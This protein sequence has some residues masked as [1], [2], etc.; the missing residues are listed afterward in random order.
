MARV[1]RVASMPRMSL[2][3]IATALRARVGDDCG[4]NAT[5]RFD[6]GAD[7]SVLIDGKSFPNRVTHDDGEA[8][9]VVG[10]SL[11]DLSALI[12]GELD[13]TTAFMTGRMKVSGDMSVALRLQRVM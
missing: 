5:L 6:C 4:L 2:D 7:G 13:P 11:A 3:E 8:D 1:S 12:E 9:C 10:M